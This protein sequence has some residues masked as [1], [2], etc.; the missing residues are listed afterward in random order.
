MFVFPCRA[1]KAPA[2]ARG[3]YAAKPREA[4]GDL[5]PELWGIP[6][7]GDFFVVDV[8]TADG[9]ELIGK[10]IG[11]E[12]PN[13]LRASTPRGVHLYFKMP[14]GVEIRNR[15]GVVEGVDVRGEG[16]YVIEW[17]LLNPAAEMAEAPAALVEL[18]RPRS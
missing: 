14:D 3:F 9:V 11:E 5:E 4:W 7:G 15:Q 6:T 17:P 10:A 18:V 16:G 13:T 2:C 1:S 8:D 12:L